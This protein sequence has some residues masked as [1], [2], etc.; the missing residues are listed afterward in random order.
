MLTQFDHRAS[1]VAFLLTKA[2]GLDEDLAAAETEFEE[3][4]C[5]ETMELV[6]HLRGQASLVRALAAQVARGDDLPVATAATSIAVASTTSPL[7]PLLTVGP[8]QN[9][10]AQ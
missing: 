8:M 5:H 2:Q 7:P 3:T 10:G 4:D 6:E 9:R 1:I